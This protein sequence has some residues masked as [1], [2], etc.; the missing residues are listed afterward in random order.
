MATE[1]LESLLKE[2]KTLDERIKSALKHDASGLSEQVKS[3]CSTLS[4]YDENDRR[5]F[6]KD[7]KDEFSK[8]GLFTRKKAKPKK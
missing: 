2:K 6:L 4:L 7:H 3:L 5:E 8:V 1:T